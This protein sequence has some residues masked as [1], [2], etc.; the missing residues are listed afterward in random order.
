VAGNF[1]LIKSVTWLPK[2]ALTQLAVALNVGLRSEIEKRG[3]RGFLQRHASAL[4]SVDDVGPESDPNWAFAP[5]R[6]STPKPELEPNPK[7]L[8]AIVVCPKVVKLPC[9]AQTPDRDCC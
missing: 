5:P 6:R 7:T 8:F 9:E 4:I 2:P 3:F 1:D